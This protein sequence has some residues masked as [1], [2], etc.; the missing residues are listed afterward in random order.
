MK[1]AA[2]LYVFLN[3]AAN[4]SAEAIPQEVLDQVPAGY[5]I[6][7]KSLRH[8][9]RELE[10]LV[11]QCGPGVIEGTVSKSDR[12]LTNR[13]SFQVH[14]DDL[15]FESPK[16]KWGLLHDPRSTYQ[17]NVSWYEPNDTETPDNF[18]LRDFMPNGQPEIKKQRCGDCWAW[19]T[20]H[21]LEITRAIHDEKVIDHSVQTVLSCSRAGSCNGGYMSAVDFLVRGLPHEQDFPYSGTDKSC[22]FSSS[23]IESGWNGKIIAAPYIGSSLAHSRG[24]RGNYR[25][26]NKVKNMMAAMAQWR[27][28]LVVTVAA[29]SISGSGIYD[30]CSA[31]NSGGN[32]MVTISGWEL[33][34]GKRVAHVWN[35]WGL[36]H[37]ENGI[38]RIRWECGDGKLN[39]GLG[40]S[41]KIVQYKSV[42][43][44]PVAAQKANHNARNGAVLIGAPQPAGTRCRW[45]PS[46]GLSDSNNCET[47]AKPSE[48]T[49]YHLIAQNHCGT[50]SSMT[51]VRVGSKSKIRTPFGNTWER[52][53]NH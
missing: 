36:S 3:V 46:E 19:A 21:G 52:T 1:F 47:L 15:F 42:C 22:K 6:D 37:G 25:E 11:N 10:E 8:A 49:E 2:M 20:H 4:Q 30:S 12:P 29:Y 33:V 14:L 39:R 31:I 26:G 40:V 23:M 7:S 5:D 45:I 48:N 51:L 16:S 38:S 27:S 41:A 24:F 43:D 34:N 18:N 53:L 50:S 44:A 9:K 13:C 17:D 35:S 28:P 32:H